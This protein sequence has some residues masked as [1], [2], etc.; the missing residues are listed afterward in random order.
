MAGNSRKSPT[1][2]DIARVSGVSATTVSFV[3]NDTPGQTIPDATRERVR[4]A[5]RELG[6]P[7]VLARAFREGTTRTVVVAIGG[8]PRGT[9]LDSFLDGLGG[10][11][12][13]HG[14][15]VAVLP[16]R[17]DALTRTIDA[18]SPRAVIDLGAIYSGAESDG[19]DGGWI[20]GLASH[21]LTQVRHLAAL[22]HTRV[23]FAQPASQNV[24]AMV[25]LRARHLRESA[26]ALEIARPVPL[27]LPEESNVDAGVLTAMVEEGVTAVAGFDDRSAARVLQSAA[28]S[29]IRIPE[30]LSLIGFDDAGWGEFTTPALTTVRIEAFEYGRRAARGALGVAASA[31]PPP[32]SHVVERGSTSA[33]VQ[34]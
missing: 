6:Y 9:A 29:G 18:I 17:G 3:L 10:E 32:Y 7:T 11:L 16:S 15:S 28:I 13:R 24:T 14:H 21:T 12:A 4:S 30:D 20:D 19:Q 2:R 23:A 25:T 1:V 33:A 27:A 5:A 22:G 8:L 34:V 31:A 26:A